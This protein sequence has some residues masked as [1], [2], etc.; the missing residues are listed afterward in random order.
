MSLAA[1][2]AA[3]PGAAIRRIAVFRALQLGDLLCAVPAL[4]A[5]RA[6]YP[7]AQITLV[8]L[9]WAAQLPARFPGYLHA[10]VEFP[11]HPGLP[12]RSPA[13]GAYGA[14]LQQMQAMRFDLALQMH[15]SGRIS[16]AIV[17]GFGAARCAGFS[18]GICGDG[19]WPY[20]HALHEIRRNLQL[21]RHL[22]ARADDERLE[23]PLT[24]ADELELHRHPGLAALPAGAYVCLH[25]GA[26]DPRKRW[27]LQSFAAVGNALAAHGWRIVITGSAAE[28]GLAMDLA[29]AMRAP[30]C[31]AACDVGLG[32][33]AVLL[34]RA[35]LLVSNDTGVAHLAAALRVPSVVVFFATDPRRWAPLDRRLHR[36]VCDPRG[37]DP[38]R[39][40]AHAEALLA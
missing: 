35:R 3:D 27:P 37:V 36:S 25:P 11:G 18:D 31:V 38:A 13:P 28:R 14:F 6:H 26:R 33:L 15:G 30:A 39:V 22:G 10:F 20:P 2:A 9:P 5:L 23:F 32:G 40:L 34:S 17:R 24:P 1:C 8:G 19:W 12:E 16:G 21:V 7:H 29:A 4:R